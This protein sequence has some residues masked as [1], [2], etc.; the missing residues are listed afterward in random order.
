M[1][2]DVKVDEAARITACK[3]AEQAHGKLAGHRPLIIKGVAEAL[4]EALALP[5]FRFAKASDSAQMEREQ[6][7]V[8]L[9]THD[10]I[11]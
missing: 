5:N 8:F 10:L 11:N 7:Q 6:N 9:K 4:I 2:C 1:L 3:P